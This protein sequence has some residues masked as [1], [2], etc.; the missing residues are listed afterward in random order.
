L[1]EYFKKGIIKEINVITD[2]LYIKKMDNCE[3]GENN[4]AL[5][6]NGKI[7]I[8]PAFYFEDKNSF[9]GSLEEGINLKDENLFKFKNAPICKNCDNYQ[10]NRC[11][12]FNRKYTNEFNIPSSLQCR[13]SSIERNASILFREKALKK[14][15]NIGTVRELNRLPYEDPI[16]V[17]MKNDLNPYKLK[18]E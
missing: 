3:F 6:P 11:V 2:T 10:C 8:C 18:S 12:F 17:I 4:F 14:N 5:G 16:A 13:I 9:I 1:L 15:I 7:Y